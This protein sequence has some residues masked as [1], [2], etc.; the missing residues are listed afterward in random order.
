MG[1]IWGRLSGVRSGGWRRSER[2]RFGEEAAAAVARGVVRDLE[3]YAGDR[4][5][6]LRD[7]FERW[8]GGGDEAG[9]RVGEM[10]AEARVGKGSFFG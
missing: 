7:H 2:G 5:A 1:G 4:E 6:D 3:V 9:G 8:A 10:Q